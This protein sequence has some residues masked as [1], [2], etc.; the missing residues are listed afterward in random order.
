MASIR[1]RV[2]DLEGL[3]E[4]LVVDMPT[5]VLVKVLEKRLLLLHIQ[6]RK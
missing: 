2:Q 6:W 1:G 4:L 5:V 3:E